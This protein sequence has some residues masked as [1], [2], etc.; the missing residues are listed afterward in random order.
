MGQGASSG[1]EIVAVGLV[2]PIKSAPFH[3][4]TQEQNLTAPR[5]KIG[6]RTSSLLTG[7]LPEQMM[8][9]VQHHVE[10]PQKHAPTW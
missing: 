9:T 1:G 3:S 7:E 2:M 10:A 8:M 6:F 4:Q 5:A